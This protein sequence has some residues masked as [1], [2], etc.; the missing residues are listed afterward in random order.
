MDDL[1]IRNNSGDQSAVGIQ[2]VDVLLRNSV[3]PG[4]LLE[5][6]RRRPRRRRNQLYHDV[7]QRP[8]G[9]SVRAPPRARVHSLGHGGGTRRRGHRL[10]LH[11]R[12]PRDLGAG[13]ERRDH[14]GH[15][16]P[17]LHHLVLRLLRALGRQH[18][19]DEH[20]LLPH[21]DPGHGNHVDDVLQ[22]GAQ[23]DRLV[24]LFDHDEIAHTVWSVWFLRRGVLP[25]LGVDHSILP[26]GVGPDF[27]RDERGVQTRLW[28][29]VRGEASQ[30]AQRAGGGSNSRY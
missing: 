4:R 15:R 19:L 2:H 13:G 1:L 16:R 21:G 28:C 27:G 24:D 18:C 26:R 12:Q 5:P 17:G 14:A 11:P 23:R 30:V 7:D 3:C 6:C 25:R 22:L 29:E 9:R 20:R 10:P 8:R